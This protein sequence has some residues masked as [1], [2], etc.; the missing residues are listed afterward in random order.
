MNCCFCFQ[1]FAKGQEH[2]KVDNYPVHYRC[3]Q[4]FRQR[5]KKELSISD[6]ILFAYRKWMRKKKGAEARILRHDVLC[7]LCERSIGEQ[8]VMVD[9][10]YCGDLIVH[11]SCAREWSDEHGKSLESGNLLE[12]LMQLNLQEG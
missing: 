8:M 10:E 9:L 11:K 4:D 7:P 2:G 5:Y 1:T 3:L 12:I 6:L